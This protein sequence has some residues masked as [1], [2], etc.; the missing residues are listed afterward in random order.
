MAFERPDPRGYQASRYS[1]IMTELELAKTFCKLSLTAG[2]SERAL[3][4]ANHAKE[5]FRTAAQSFTGSSL[6]DEMSR[7]IL[8]EIEA[9]TPLLEQVL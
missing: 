1:F 3:R 8:A 5:A 2:D 6:P 7:E 4:N 9:L